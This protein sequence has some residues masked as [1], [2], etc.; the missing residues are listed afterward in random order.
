MRSGLCD[1]SWVCMPMR[2]V[3]SLLVRD[4][5]E[6]FE[7]MVHAHQGSVL[8]PLLFIIVLEALSLVFCAGVPW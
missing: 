2:G 8:S 7:V 3:L 6:E 4:T 5:S 1:W